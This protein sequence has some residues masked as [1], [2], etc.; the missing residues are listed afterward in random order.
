MDEPSA[1][2]AQMI[3]NYRVIRSIGSG[4]TCKVVLAEAVDTGQLVAI[5]RIK[6]ASL[7]EHPGLRDK[8]MREISLMRLCNHPHLL[9]FVEAFQSLRH[10]YLILEYAPGGELF[11]LLMQKKKLD[12]SLAMR[13]F[14]QLVYGLEFLHGHGICHRDLKPEN[15]LLS[16]HH[17]I[18]IADFGFARWMKADIADTSCGTPHYAAPEVIR[19][20]PYDGRAADVWS[21]GVILYALV[22]GWLPFQDKALRD[23]FAKVKNGQYVM[24][25]LPAE[26][27]DLIARMLVVDP[28][29][30]IKLSE[31]KA[32]PVF[33]CDLPA[34]LVLP[35]PLPVAVPSQPVDPALISEDV[36]SALEQIGFPDR[37]ELWRELV[38]P[39]QTMA[40]VFFGMLVT[41]AVEALPWGATE[42]AAVPPEALMLTPLS[43][44][45]AAFE[46]AAAESLGF[47]ASASERLPLPG[48]PPARP[49]GHDARVR[50][51]AHVARG[52]ARR[53]AEV[54]LR[55]RLRVVP[56]G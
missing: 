8:L 16:D 7:T 39:G 20:V 6:I 3:G 37:G 42:V 47:G 1:A 51:R 15:L 34:A 24:P 12:F 22:C 28:G 33:R 11:H 50:R 19:G 43:A 35:T 5:K 54:P 27:Q 4:S 48:M 26:L 53:A 32:H 40:K 55:P 41:D 56:P 25:P 49:M 9:K 38:E 46:V 29:R 17:D 36:L 44:G 23:L 13:F 45:P 52:H 14:R 10:M 31:I 18:K 2:R 30:R 21:C